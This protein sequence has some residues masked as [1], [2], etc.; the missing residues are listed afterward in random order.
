MNLTSTGGAIVNSNDEALHTMIHPFEDHTH[1][2][3]I[4]SPKAFNSTSGR[5]G[6]G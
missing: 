3:T 6:A 4:R 5:G 1:G 2:Y